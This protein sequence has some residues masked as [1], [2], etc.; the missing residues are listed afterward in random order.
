MDAQINAIMKDIRKRIDLMYGKFTDD[1]KEIPELPPYEEIEKN[2][3]RRYELAQELTSL[4]DE[5]MNLKLRIRI[6]V[7]YIREMRKIQITA[8]SEYAL[9]QS[10]KDGLQRNEAYLTDTL[11]DIA[12]LIRNANNKLKVLDNLTWGEM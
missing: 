7:K 11:F 1:N 4:I 8:R 10:F 12:D 2:S 9:I 3:R 6:V 5:L